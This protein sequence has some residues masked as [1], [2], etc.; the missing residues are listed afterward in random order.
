MAVAWRRKLVEVG[1]SSQTI[2]LLVVVANDLRNLQ[3]Q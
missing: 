1:I 2:S 3:K